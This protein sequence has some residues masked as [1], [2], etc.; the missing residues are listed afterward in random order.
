MVVLLRFGASNLTTHIHYR[1]LQTTSWPHRQSKLICW[2]LR[3]SIRSI[4]TFCGQEV[5]ASKR[6]ERVVFKAKLPQN[7]YF[8]YVFLFQVQ[9]PDSRIGKEHVTCCDPGLVEA[10][11]ELRSRSKAYL[12]AH[13]L[14]KSLVPAAWMQAWVSQPKHVQLLQ[15]AL[16]NKWELLLPLLTCTIRK[17]SGYEVGSSLPKAIR[18]SHIIVC[19][20]DT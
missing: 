1:L 17:P 5:I 7:R 14:L 12:L 8:T 15:M 11:R 3:K 4:V 10:D 20:C 16:V 2:Q 18:T 6:E 13:L 9:L 19:A